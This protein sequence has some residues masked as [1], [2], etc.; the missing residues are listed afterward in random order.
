MHNDDTPYGNLPVLLSDRG[1]DVNA[2]S[3]MQIS[4]SSKNIYGMGESSHPVNS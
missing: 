2:A 4:L 3:G 1:V